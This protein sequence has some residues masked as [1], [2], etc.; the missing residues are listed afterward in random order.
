LKIVHQTGELD[1]EKVEKGYQDA[2]WTADIRR[3]ITDMVAEF[4]KSDLV[5]CRAGATTCAEL[6]AAGKVAIMVPLPTAADDHQRKNAE[7]LQKAGAARM[8]LQARLTGESLAKE[9]ESLI[10]APERIGEMERSAKTLAK[11]D[12]AEKAVDIIEELAVSGKQ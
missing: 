5:I 4:A 10:D 6:A 11:A 8:I 7:A 2:G 12:A 9:I 3:Y 1:F